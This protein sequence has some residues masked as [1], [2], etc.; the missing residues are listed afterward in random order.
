MSSILSKD[1][2]IK[3]APSLHSMK[4]NSSIRLFKN[5]ELVKLLKERRKKG[6]RNLPPLPV[7]KSNVIYDK[8]AF[9]SEMSKQLLMSQ[10]FRKPPLKLRS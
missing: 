1:D 6:K 10:D 5:E 2:S 9:T 7:I 8:D 3:Y 4:Q